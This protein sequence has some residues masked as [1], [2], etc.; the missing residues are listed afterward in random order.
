MTTL[1]A[2]AQ[3][4]DATDARPTYTGDELEETFS[5]LWGTDAYVNLYRTAGNRYNAVVE[6]GNGHCVQLFRPYPISREFLIDDDFWAA[7]VL[8]RHQ[9]EEQREYA[10]QR[11]A[12]AAGT[13]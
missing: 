9:D 6:D 11:A 8:N 4:M 1:A 12:W 13:L 10:E 5:D 7:A 3:R 2:F